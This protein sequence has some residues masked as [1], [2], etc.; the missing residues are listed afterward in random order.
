V[1]KSRLLYEFENWLELLPEWVWLGKGRAVPEMSL[2]PYALIRDLFAFRFQIKD[3]DSAV[4]AREKLEQGVT[5]FLGS[6]EGG[7]LR[8]HFIGHLLGF[9][10]SASSYLQGV[11]EDVQ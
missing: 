6:D 4:V 5:A 3:S 10:F 8:A 1:G 9:D 11:L 7:Q 2:W